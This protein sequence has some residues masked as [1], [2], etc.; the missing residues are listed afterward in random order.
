MNWAVPLSDVT[1]GEEEVR[2]VAEALRSGWLT[3][4]ARVEEFERRFAAAVGARHAVA[5]TNGTAALHLAYAAVGL[6]AGEEFILPAL[7]FVAT[8]N[9]GLYL[10]GRPVLADCASTDDLTLAVEDVARKIT[11]RTRLIVSMPYGGFCPD[12]AA[13]KELAGAKGI[14]LVE[15][16]CHAPLASINGRC[17]GTWGAAGAFSFFGNKNLTTGEG[18][19]VV[20]DDEALAARVRSLRSHGMSTLTWDRHR[21]YAADYDV[22]EVGYNYRLDEVRAAIGIAQLAKLA[23]SNRRRAENAA[24]LRKAIES[25]G[26]CRRVC[27]AGVSP[28]PDAQEARRIVAGET[29][30]LPAQRSS[31]GFSN[32]LRDVPGLEIPFANPRG[33]PVHHLFVILLPQGIERAAFRAKMAEDGIQTSVHYP[34][35][36]RFSVA[37]AIF[38]ASS[39]LRVPVFDSLADRLVTLPMGPHLTPESIGRIAGAVGKALRA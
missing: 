13:L 6:K 14:L 32:G 5:V 35:L 31:G 28:T 12:M 2:A 8:M 38:G 36:H 7:T 9:A 20:T 30:A 16:A 22:T 15:D 29:P 11:P 23:E 21:G 10:G 25:L 34:P 27:S 3:Q 18:G 17:M 37:R 1:V 24:Q 39:D 26:A 4:G 33:H 19:M